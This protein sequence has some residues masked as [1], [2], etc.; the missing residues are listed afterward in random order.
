MKNILLLSFFIT[1]SS[2]API[3]YSIDL[4]IKQSFKGFCPRFSHYSISKDK[5]D[6]SSVTYKKG[7]KSPYDIISLFNIERVSN[8][9]IL[10]SISNNIFKD[11][12]FI[13]SWSFYENPNIGDYGFNKR[14]HITE[15]KFSNQKSRDELFSIPQDIKRG[16]GY[17]PF[18]YSRLIRTE[19]SIVIVE[20]EFHGSLK[21]FYDMIKRVY[22]SEGIFELWINK[23]NF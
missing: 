2:F 18:P 22:S 4:N 11:V 10:T 23:Q 3:T 17:D 13:C 12:D 19:S 21:E 9:N 7:G 6:L 14:V 5:Y 20:Q 8:K 15:I 16:L 1:L